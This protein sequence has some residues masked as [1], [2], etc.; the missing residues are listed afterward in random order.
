VL[1]PHQLHNRR[2]PAVDLR[3]D[4]ISKLNQ[5]RRISCGQYSDILHNF[6][7]LLSFPR[8]CFWVFFHVLQKGVTHPVITPL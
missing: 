2:N 1:L 5:E 6:S 4:L 3:A 8:H 7:G